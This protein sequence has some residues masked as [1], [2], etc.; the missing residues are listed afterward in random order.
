M[1]GFTLIETLVYIALLS[2]LMIGVFSSVFI[3]INKEQRSD[4]VEADSGMLNQT[5]YE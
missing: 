5:F 4:Q 1:K 2:V 3:F